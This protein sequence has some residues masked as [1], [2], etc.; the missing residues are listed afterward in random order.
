MSCWQGVKSKC[1]NVGS[2]VKCK[3]D[4]VG[5]SVNRGVRRSYA[6]LKRTFSREDIVADDEDERHKYLLHYEAN[7]FDY[8]DDEGK[9]PSLVHSYSKEFLS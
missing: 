5:S 3:V 1:D 9:L 7:Y 8:S 2:S 6:G 4:H